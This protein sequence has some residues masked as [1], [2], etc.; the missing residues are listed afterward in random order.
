MVIELASNFMKFTVYDSRVLWLTGN[1]WSD[2]T[3]KECEDSSV[4]QSGAG[5]DRQSMLLRSRFK[6]HPFSRFLVIW[7]LLF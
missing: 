4:Y 7:P 1:C 3:D 2:H 5:K 6:S